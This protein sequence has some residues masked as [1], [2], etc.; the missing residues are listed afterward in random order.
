MSSARSS[1][2][3]RKGCACGVAPDRLLTPKE[4][5]AR[6]GISPGTL[7]NWA[8][9]GKGPRRYPLSPSFGSAVRY[10]EAEVNAFV[11][12]VKDGELAR[13]PRAAGTSAVLRA[14][15]A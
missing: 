4:A 8:R 6:I 9:I 2:S 14:A 7:K 12:A 10:S 15:G 5:A 3:P 11:Q 13:P 1:R